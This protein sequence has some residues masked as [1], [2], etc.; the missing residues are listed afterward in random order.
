MTRQLPLRY[1]GLPTVKRAGPP[2]GEAPSP[3][4]DLYDELRASLD[5]EVR[6]DEGSRA[7]YSTDASNYRYTPIGVVLPRTIDDVIATV[8][9]CRRHGAPITSRGG[10]TSLAGQTTNTAVIIDFSKYL[11]HVMAIDADARRAVVQPGCNTDH[12]KHEAAQHGLTWGPD[13]STHSRNTL[14]GM[15]GNN[16]CGT[17]SVMSQ[18]Y[19]PGPLTED[20]VID[21]D[22][23]TYA[24][25]RMTVG[26]HTEDEVDE[27]IAAGGPRGDIYRRLRALRDTY[28]EQIA[29]GF[30]DIPRRVSGFNLDRLQAEAGFDVAKALVGTEGTCVTVLHATVELIPAM[31]ERELIVLAYPDVYAAADAVPALMAHRPVALE[32]L[33]DK[34]ISFMRRK[35][36]HPEDVSLLPDGGGWLLMEF[37]GDDAAQVAE[38]VDNLTGELDAA[39][40]PPTARRFTDSWQIAQIWRIRES[41][42]GASS[43]VPGVPESHTGWEDA[44]VEPGQLGEYIRRFRSLLDEFGYDASLYGHFGQGCL[45][46]RIDF[47]LRTGE[48]IR[49]W[50]TFLDRAADLVVEHGGS[51][52]GE[53]GDGQ[54]R[55]AL[56]SRMYGP[57]LVR[58]FARF[59]AIWDPDNCMNPNRVVDPP[60]PTEHLREGVDYR[61]A[62]V[63]TRFAFPT[64]DGDFANAVNRCVGVGL[65]R[66]VDS[67]TMCPSYM[68]TREEEDS[69]RGRARMLFE[70]LN[71]DL[72][73]EGWRSDAVA[74]SLELC[75]SCKSC[76]HECPVNVDMATYKAEFLSHH[77]R[78]RLRPIAA[79]SMGLIYWWARLA[80]PFA[81]LVNAVTAVPALA[82]LLKRLGG[83]APQRSIP[84]FASP[85]FR[86]WF[87][88]RR[89]AR[90]TQ[91]ATSADYPVGH[92][93]VPRWNGERYRHASDEGPHASRLNPQQARR[94]FD[95]ER[96]LLWP[97]TFSNYL[98]TDALRA[99]VAVLEDAGYTVEIPP[100][101]LCCGR[102]LYDF[103]MLA[104]ATR[105]WRQMIDTLRPWIRDGVP[106]VGV[107]PSCVAAFRDELPGLLPR[108]EDAHR[109]AGQTLDFTEFLVRQRYQPPP[110]RRKALV[111]GHC[112]HKAIMH[113]DDEIAILKAMELDLSVPDVGC[114][115]MAGSFGFTAGDHY[116][117]SVRAG[118]RLLLPKVRAAEPT[119]L[120]V[121]NGFS[122]HQQIAQLTDRTPLHVAE[123]I[124]MALE[125]GPD[126][127]PGALPEERFRREHATG[128]RRR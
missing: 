68:A 19:G 46:C 31:P 122:C 8:A 48:G 50:R 116:E 60:G 2:P 13:P 105:L 127:V 51:L 56:L 54:A 89:R 93:D 45:H 84:R 49:Q 24:G 75:L 40:D 65:C 33:D 102:P 23:L 106:V 5:G 128:R 36:L 96:V 98:G 74:D 61:P 25:D 16:S 43:H 71:G 53:H 123:L 57:D 37:G 80:A 120:I 111:H 117:V 63:T 38:Q 73:A 4:T 12:L 103:G 100:R 113:M 1:D 81:R 95:T 55:A 112:H 26:A 17:H 14:G 44:A 21:L 72:R 34:L 32:G 99:A 79:Y 7:A 70:M 77:Y 121:T 85:T 94:P 62:Q 22:I 3:E 125:H 39:D 67:G 58:A 114:C 101:S 87:T 86:A 9:A 15:I 107:E 69:T 64:D 41:G 124:Q 20:Q 110:L 88:R 30:P 92:V 109:L 76:K 18:F 104:T 91:H 6:F 82:S 29:T 119:T 97:D 90:G 47:D 10:G 126:G 115:G 42:L 78:G 11:W 118:E 66:D 59:K 83:V 28:A 27:I 52:S 108:D 35:G